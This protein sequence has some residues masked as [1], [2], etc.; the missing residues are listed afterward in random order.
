MLSIILCR[1][2]SENY[3]KGLLRLVEN[4]AT[5]F[6]FSTVLSTYV[7]VAGVLLDG[8]ET[9]FDLGGTESLMGIRREF[10]PDAGRALEPSFFVLIDKPE[11]QVDVNQLWVRENQLVYGLSLSEAKPFREADYV[12]YSIVQTSERQDETMLPF[13][14]LYEQVKQWASR[15]DESSW[16]QAKANMATLYQTL[17]LSPD[18]TPMHARKLINTYVA[19]MRQ[20]HSEAIGL[21]SLGA[22]QFDAGS[23][24]D[25]VTTTLSK[26]TEILDLK[27]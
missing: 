8:V 19:E 13:Y 1:V 22:G 11:S 27:L 10:D 20:L 6:D 7:K 12:L 14:P 17:V 4:A 5:A 23:L 24:E 25:D 2:E 18:L 16:Q 3:A 26:A 21:G 15:S 9:L